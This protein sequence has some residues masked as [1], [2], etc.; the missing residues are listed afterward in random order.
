MHPTVLD[1]LFDALRGVHALRGHIAACLYG[2]RAAGYAKRNSDW[3]ILAILESYRDGLRYHQARHDGFR[4]TILAVDRALFELDCRKGTLGEF[5]A[6]RIL[7]PYVPLKNPTYLQ[8]MELEAKLRVA[9]EELE[10][11]IVEHGELARGVVVTPEYVALSRAA[12]RAKV[13]LPAR[14]NYGKTYTGRQA[15][16]NL[17]EV[18]AGYAAALGKL[19]EAGSVRFDGTRASLE[20]AYVDR[21]MQR[22][23]SERVVNITEVSRRAVNA[24]LM[25]GRASLTSLDALANE[26]MRTISTQII[27]DGGEKGP[28]DPRRHLF[29]KTETGLVPFDEK[30][31][32]EELARRLHPDAAITVEPLGG[33]LNDVYLVWAGKNRFVAKQFTDWHGFKWFILN[34][35][36]IGTKTFTVSGKA[37]L[38][39]EYGLSQYLTEHNISA[40]AI[41]YVSLP[42]RIL[43]KEFIDGSTGT[44]FVKTVSSQKSLS[45]QQIHMSRMLGENLAAIH[46][47]DASV[48]DSKPENFQLS[49]DRVFAL[50]LEQGARPGDPAWD[51]A[52]FLYYS[53]HHVLSGIPKGGFSEFL[54]YFIDGYLKN[55]RGKILKEAASL[56]YSK[57]FSLWT[58]TP[59]LL[60]VSQT[61]RKAG[62]VSS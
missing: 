34:L 30:A 52:E 14:Q 44:E 5:I 20:G 60:E 21:V 54:R 46:A 6:G 36:S 24:Y 39:N 12:K 2:S 25:H 8:R 61:L 27:P 59:I 32:V 58:P 26:L 49:G 28:A 45:D 56:K 16:T 10:D 53:G 9:A 38:S 29:L 13:F 3:D 50:D 43:I 23:D 1:G 22:R 18:S 55:G 17:K 62:K 11:L 41:I 51:V 37:R 33:V 57:V 48:G 40:P 42:D 4:L 15:E 7:S 31:S 35:V 19:A 47:S